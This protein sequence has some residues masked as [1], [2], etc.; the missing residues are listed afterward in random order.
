[1]EGSGDAPNPVKTETAQR[2]VK[3]PPGI[4]Q[5]EFERAMEDLRSLVGAEHVA[6]PLYFDSTLLAADAMLFTGNQR[7]TAQRR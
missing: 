1:M 3:L 6:S 5:R 2:E 4:G 7:G